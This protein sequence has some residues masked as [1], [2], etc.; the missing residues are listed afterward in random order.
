MWRACCACRKLVGT[1]G[2]DGLCN[3]QRAG[4]GRERHRVGACG[5]HRLFAC[6]VLAHLCAWLA[7]MRGEMASLDG[8]RGAGQREARNEPS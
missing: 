5:A 7:D 4:V 3:R 8:V 6:D 2:D 1:I